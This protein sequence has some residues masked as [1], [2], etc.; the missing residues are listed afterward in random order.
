M[1]STLARTQQTMKNPAKVL[2]HLRG[3]QTLGLLAVAVV[4]AI[5]FT[6][7]SPYFLT[8]D[9]IRN[10]LI[11]VSVIGTMSAVLTLVVVSGMLDLSVGSAAAL[12][13]VAAATVTT[14]WGWSPIYGVV[15]ALACG[16]ACGL[17]N[18]L[19]VTSVK[20]NP[21]I[22]TIGTLSVFRGLA[23]IVT[24][25]RDV[26]VNDPI[27]DF[28]AFDKIWFVPAPVFIMLVVFGCT[29]WIAH[30]TTFGRALYA[31]GANPK[32]ARLAGLPMARTRI[33]ILVAMGVVV[34]I[35]ALVLNA[36]SGSAVPGAANGYELQALTAVL[37]GGASLQGGEGRISGTLLGVLIIGII[38]NGMTL[39]SVP[40]FYQTV[41]SGVLLLVAV[42]IDQLRRG[43][44]FQ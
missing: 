31:I 18:A 28:L 1:T 39:L 9:N 25:G 33:V 8:E 4:A 26:A 16:A 40:S 36:Q 23:F 24:D 10:I 11:S 15:A 27:S 7:A 43:G 35:A 2:S 21:I 22:V 44:G 38:N 12:S 17:F 41:A 32:A 37:L 3:S 29:A 20:I 30:Q 14:T 34:G 6:I 13:A 5:G 42:A 19:I